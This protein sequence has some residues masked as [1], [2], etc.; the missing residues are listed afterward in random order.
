[1]TSLAS[2]D[3]APGM[4]EDGHPVSTYAP[5]QLLPGG[6]E[7]W[8]RLGVGHRCETWLAWSPVL[9]GPVVVKFPR[10][11]QSEHPRAR[12]SLRR[13]VTALDGNLHPGLPR[14]Y[15]DGTNADEPFVVF[16]YVDGPALDDELDD[17][18]PMAADDVALLGVH[19]LSALRTVHARGVVHVDIKPANVVVR[20]GRPVLVDFGSSRRRGAT[21]PAGLLI[22][23][24][25]YAA[26]E[27][28]AG[29]PI[30]ESMDVYGVGV[31]LHE[32]RTGAPT[33]DPL[34]PAADRGKP[35][36]LEPGAVSDLIN[37]LLRTDPDARPTAEEALRG[38]SAIASAT[39]PDAWPPWLALG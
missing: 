14:L 32:A 15:A 10:P 28:E 29:A 35:A 19:L 1:M 39:S 4:D 11:H 3:P 8:D 34:L 36:R 31:T 27:L 2:I 6:V 37:D 5:G 13:E 33:F 17:H 26:P 16:E 22:G 38:F 18:G 20:A 7:A 24:P 25:G 23:S 12:Q 21:Q 9:W 30:G